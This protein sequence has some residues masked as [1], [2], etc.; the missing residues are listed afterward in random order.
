MA[1]LDVGDAAPDFELERDGGARVKLSS[2]RGSTVVLFFYP[3]D[4]TPGCTLEAR[5]FSQAATRFASAGVKVFGVS[6]DSV[7]SHCRF[8][9][10]YGLAVPLLSDPS[11]DV[12]R[13]YGVWGEKMMYGRKVEG[14]VRST[15]VVGPDGALKA[16][17]RGVKV[18]G[19]VDKLLAALTPDAT[20]LG[21]LTDPPAAKAPAA[22]SKPAATKKAPAVKK[23]PAA[24]PAAKKKPAAKS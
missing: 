11:L 7:A 14:T 2:L 15:F 8:R 5:G 9:D 16:V 20:P 4:N 17:H 19:H 21:P 3:K 12:H 13:A 6:R 23:T 22:T 10:K 24:K 1:Q 18:D